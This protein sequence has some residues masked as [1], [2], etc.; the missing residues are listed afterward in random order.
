M[1][2][3]AEN[4]VDSVDQPCFDDLL[5]LREQDLRTLVVAASARLRDEQGSSAPDSQAIEKAGIR[6]AMACEALRQASLTLPFEENAALIDS[7]FDSSTEFDAEVLLRTAPGETL[8]LLQA[9]CEDANCCLSETAKAAVVNAHSL[10]VHQ[11]AGLHW[12]TVQA[13]PSR[14]GRAP[15]G[16]SALTEDM[17]LAAVVTEQ[18]DRAEAEGRLK[19]LSAPNRGLPGIEELV[20]GTEALDLARCSVELRPITGIPVHYAHVVVKDA[21]WLSDLIDPNQLIDLGYWRIGIQGQPGCGKSRTIHGAFAGI[22][23]V[24]VTELARLASEQTQYGLRSYQDQQGGGDGLR[25][26]TTMKSMGIGRGRLRSVGSADK[27]SR[28]VI[29]ID[30]AEQSARAVATGGHYGDDRCLAMHE[31]RCTAA[32]LARHAETVALVMTDADLTLETAVD[33]AEDTGLPGPLLFLEIITPSRAPMRFA[34]SA[35]LPRLL[36]D[37]ADSQDESRSLAL[38]LGSTS[39]PL[40]LEILCRE[41][42]LRMVSTSASSRTPRAAFEAAQLRQREHGEGSIQCS[43][44]AASHGTNDDNGPGNSEAVAAYPRNAGISPR[45]SYQAVCR[46]RKADHRTIIDEGLRASGDADFVLQRDPGAVAAALALPQKRGMQVWDLSD[47]YDRREDIAE[48]FSVVDVQWPDE[49]CVELDPEQFFRLMAEALIKAGRVRADQMVRSEQATSAETL[50]T[51]VDRVRKEQQAAAKSALFGMSRRERMLADLRDK[52]ARRGGE[53]RPSV[54]STLSLPERLAAMR[55]RFLVDGVMAR[56]A[57]ARLEPYLL[58]LDRA[59]DRDVG[60]LLR[61]PAT[62][63][64]ESALRFQAVLQQSSKRLRQIQAVQPGL[65][66]EVMDDMERRR[67]RHEDLSLEESMAYDAQMHD[68]RLHPLHQGLMRLAALMRATQD[69]SRPP[70][71]LH[72]LHLAAGSP[73]GVL[74][75]MRQAQLHYSGR[76]RTLFDARSLKLLSS[77]SDDALDAVGPWRLATTDEVRDAVLGPALTEL[78]KL[79]FRAVILDDEIVLSTRNGVPSRRLGRMT[80]EAHAELGEYVALHRALSHTFKVKLRLK[81][82]SFRQAEVRLVDLFLVPGLAA[83][84]PPLMDEDEAGSFHRRYPELDALVGDDAPKNTTAR[85]QIWNAKNRGKRRRGKAKHK[86]AQVRGSRHAARLA[87][88]PQLRMA[89]LEAA[90]RQLVRAQESQ[91]I[92]STFVTTK[93]KQRLKN[94][95]ERIAKYEAVIQEREATVGEAIVKAEAAKARSEALRTSNAEIKLTRPPKWRWHS[96]LRKL[97]LAIFGVESGVYHG[98]NNSLLLATGQPEARVPKGWVSR[99]TTSFEAQEKDERAALDAMRVDA[100]RGL[101]AFIGQVVELHVS[102]KPRSCVDVPLVLR[103]QELAS[104]AHWFAL[105]DEHGYTEAGAAPAPRASMRRGL[106]MC[107]VIHAGLSGTAPLA[108]MEALVGEGQTVMEARAL[109]EGAASAAATE[110]VD[111]EQF[112]SHRETTVRAL[113]ALSKHV[114]FASLERAHTLYQRERGLLDSTA[115]LSDIRNA[116]EADAVRRRLRLLAFRGDVM[117]DGEAS[118]HAIFGGL[119]TALDEVRVMEA[120]GAFDGEQ[121]DAKPPAETKETKVEAERPV[122]TQEA[123]M[124]RAPW[125]FGAIDRIRDSERRFRLLEGSEEAVQ[126]AI[127]T[128]QLVLE[129]ED[130]DKAR[131]EAKRV[132]LSPLK[133]LAKHKSG[134]IWTYTPAPHARDASIQ[135]THGRRFCPIANT[136]KTVRSTWAPADEANQVVAVDLVA[137]FM[138]LGLWARTGIELLEGDFYGSDIMGFATLWKRVMGS[139]PMDGSNRSARK[140]LQLIATNMPSE[141]TRTFRERA[142]TIFRDVGCTLADEPLATELERWVVEVRRRQRF[143]VWSSILERG[144][145]AANHSHRS[146]TATLQGRE[147]QLGAFEEGA[148]NGFSAIRSRAEHSLETSLIN[149]LVL[150]AEE[151]GAVVSFTVH[152]CLYLEVEREGAE[153]IVERTLARWWDRCTDLDLP[154]LAVSWGSS[155]TYDV[156]RDREAAS[157]LSDVQRCDVHVAASRVKAQTDKHQDGTTTVRGWLADEYGSLA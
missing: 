22:P 132:S 3:L 62:H 143:S 134:E 40:Q 126:Q 107:R 151:E 83:A 136:A 105:E 61:R 113:T 116:K 64:E 108:A 2:G 19:Q 149:Q 125:S 51:A 84:L 70:K 46:D 110:G 114:D 101:A 76:R 75:L 35:Y 24:Y 88:G 124:K 120:N 42:G 25:H 8:K 17:H 30:E 68:R 56:M 142:T 74:E 72:A 37:R 135:G 80:K 156:T 78:Q 145:H 89:S 36:G 150:A 67:R 130:A 5:L 50:D 38:A 55:R 57:V 94:A 154:R 91:A 77:T 109:L 73:R 122:Q 20:K 139:V 90:K 96:W 53:D 123:D 147:I 7:V 140:L 87:K 92:A 28:G 112:G 13:P 133:A 104:K 39:Q 129:D 103:M 144:G 12:Q 6:Y 18:T 26:A 29:V 152:D 85:R 153:A 98:E 155:D 128:A 127:T 47:I 9:A 137:G 157:A 63:A 23:M 33:L 131:K 11:E 99:P 69:T 148:W 31:L 44:P 66:D 111:L 4:A 79:G 27:H 117:T 71:I 52:A 1:S 121:D 41:L 16:P 106:E 141:L 81:D 115:K 65:S 45:S 118:H 138:L 14:S 119:L 100:E 10:L 97:S 34:S 49:G 21:V 95:T 48:R 86:A 58:A 54:Q 82:A 43:S 32:E 60:V 59:G 93:A 146:W 15:R 102:W